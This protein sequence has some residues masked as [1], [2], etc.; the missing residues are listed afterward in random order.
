MGIEI[1]LQF[2][3]LT[4]DPTTP[5]V[6][7]TGT[8]YTIEKETNISEESSAGVFLGFILNT[9]RTILFLLSLVRE[10]QIFDIGINKEF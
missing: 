2:I 6:D 8:T 10:I 3:Y 7:E 1:D 4:D 9:P 5:D